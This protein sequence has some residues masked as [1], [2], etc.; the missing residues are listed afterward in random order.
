MS[1]FRI[2]I[3]IFDKKQEDD[4]YGQIKEEF[5]D[6]FIGY[7]RDNNGKISV[8]QKVPFMLGSYSVGYI[9]FLENSEVVSDP[10]HVS[11]N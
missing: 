11:Y 5:C 3:Q 6:R 8:F 1:N 2:V 9:S 10:F 4:Y 7:L